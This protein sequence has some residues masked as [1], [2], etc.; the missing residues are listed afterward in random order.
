MRPLVPGEGSK[1]A[2]K[3]LTEDASAGTGIAVFL[4]RPHVPNVLY[5]RTE[6]LRFRNTL[7]SRSGIE[8]IEPLRT[9]I[10]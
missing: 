8:V 4:F 9:V 3:F 6:T 7:F 10:F 2:N 5:E 1:S